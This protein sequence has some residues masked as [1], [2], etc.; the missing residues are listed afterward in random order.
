[1]TKLIRL[2]A[3]V[4]V[5]GLVASACGGDSAGTPDTTAGALTG[6]Q[7]EDDRGAGS[8]SSD[9]TTTTLDR[10]VCHV[11][12]PTPIPLGEATDGEILGWD[13]CF[14]VE[15]P[16][17][18]AVFTVEL[19]GL[20]DQLNLTAGY[21]DPETILYNTGD[22]WAS[23]EDGLADESIVI[24]NPEPGTYYINV[25]VATRRNQSPFTLTTT[26]S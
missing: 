11:P 26:T 15:V 2:L 17:G 9:E 22:F 18:A 19:T 16:A 7:S 6:T 10:V 21:A 13:Q 23:R 1:M 4:L 5:C 20:Q 24:E 3:P 8:A 25:A 12:E 14:T